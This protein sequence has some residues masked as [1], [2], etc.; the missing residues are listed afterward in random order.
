MLKPCPR[1]DRATRPP[2]EGVWFGR[3]SP[4]WGTSHGNDHV[5]AVHAGQSGA[6]ARSRHWLLGAGQDARGAVSWPDARATPDHAGRR[7][8][9]GAHPWAY[10]AASHGSGGRWHPHA[11]RVGRKHAGRDVGQSGNRTALF[12]CGRAVGACRNGVFATSGAGRDRH[13]QLRPA[14]GLT[15]RPLHQTRPRRAGCGRL[16]LDC[17]TARALGHGSFARLQRYFPMPRWLFGLSRR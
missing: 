14:L 2:G 1:K 4:Y 9:G 8:S 13:S 15:N 7:A 12:G 16:G 10:R 3:Y 11:D 5:P 6:S 17:H